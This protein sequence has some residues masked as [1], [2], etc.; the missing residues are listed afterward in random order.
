M[1]LGINA[2]CKAVSQGK[3]GRD[4][5]HVII[6]GKSDLNLFVQ[7]I[8]AVGTYKLSTLQIIE[9][10]LRGRKANTNRDIIPMAAWQ[11]YALPAMKIAN[12]SQRDMQAQ[13]QVP[14]CGITLFKQNM[15][16]ERAQR[17]ATV[18]RSPELSK[19]ASSDLYW[20]KIVSI[21]PDGVEEV[22]DLTV[23]GHH[24]F[25]ANNIIAHNSIEQDADLIMMLYREEYYDPDTP[26]RG[27]AE[28]IIAKHRNGPTGTVKLLFEPQYTL[29]RNLAKPNS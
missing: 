2:R 16:R 21:E 25:V 19:L 18:V 17:V 14:Y 10:Y 22:F 1:R 8:G 3:K 13:L 4:Q 15:S 26:D 23:P 29:F 7:L 20:D 11:L 28:V 24:N 6:T 12:L 9:D 27:L 5:Y